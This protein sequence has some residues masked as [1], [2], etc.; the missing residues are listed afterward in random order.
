MPEAPAEA[1]A[2]VIAVV[3]T[4]TIIEEVRPEAVPV[5]EGAILVIEPQAP[6]PE[7]PAMAPSAAAEVK[8][9]TIKVEV[10]A[11][12]ELNVAVAL[13]ARE[14]AAP[15][16]GNPPPKEWIPQAVSNERSLGKVLKQAGDR[17]G[18]TLTVQAGLVVAFCVLLAKDAPRTG[19]V[20]IMLGG[21]PLFA[22]VLICVGLANCHATQLLLDNL[23]SERLQFQ[24]LGAGTELPPDSFSNARRLAYWPSLIFLGILLVVWLCLGLTVWF[25][26]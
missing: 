3:E 1:P 22:M 15:D 5:S 23:E 2:P 12:E 8:T 10:P 19:M 11:I 21:I 4:V 17:I 20:Q 7:E 14:A 25:L 13:E 24:R 16:A 9:E 18:W 26:A 6:Q